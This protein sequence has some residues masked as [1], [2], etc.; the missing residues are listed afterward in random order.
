[1]R[2]QRPLATRRSERFTQRSMTARTSPFPR[3]DYICDA[4][5]TAVNHLLFDT[6]SVQARSAQSVG[7]APA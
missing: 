5:A 2:C 7:S 1:M 3:P 4:E 6:H